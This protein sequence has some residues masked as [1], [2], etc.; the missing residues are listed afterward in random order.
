MACLIQNQDAG[1]ICKNYYL[2]ALQHLQCSP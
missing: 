1:F 2:D